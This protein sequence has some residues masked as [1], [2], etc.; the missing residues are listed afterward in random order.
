MTMKARFLPADLP[1]DRR[2]VRKR[3]G[4]SAVCLPRSRQREEFLLPVYRITGGKEPQ[5]PGGVNGKQNHIS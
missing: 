1:V 3:C 5:K 2:K 4:G